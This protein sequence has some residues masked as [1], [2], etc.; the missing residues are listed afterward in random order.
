MNR[1]TVAG[2]VLIGVSALLVAFVLVRAG[3][4]PRSP[5]D[6]AKTLLYIC[7]NPACG[8]VQRLPA[9]SQAQWLA[10]RFPCPI[11]GKDTLAFAERCTACG[12][13]IPRPLIKDMPT[14]KCPKCGGPVYG[15]SPKRNKELGEDT[16]P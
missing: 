15:R 11:C 3:W 12:E 6:V 8:K 5:D 7:T 13:L 10:D 16:P 4:G 2:V 9:P 1:L 14:A